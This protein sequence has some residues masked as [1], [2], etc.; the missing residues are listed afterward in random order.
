MN[1]QGSL[2]RRPVNLKRSTCQSGSTSSKTKAQKPNVLIW[3][4]SANTTV[5]Q[6]EEGA[7]NNVNL[8]EARDGVYKRSKVIVNNLVRNLG[9]IALKRT[10]KDDK[11]NSR[12]VHSKGKVNYKSILLAKYSPCIGIN[13]TEKIE[14]RPEGTQLVRRNK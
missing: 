2:D 10:R 5:K 7:C 12:S 9:I 11:C 8:R 4:Q 3:G 6:I 13:N 1:T 14:I